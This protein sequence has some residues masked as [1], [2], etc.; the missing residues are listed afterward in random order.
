[1]LV[2]VK[3]MGWSM[4]NGMV[5]RGSSMMMWGI[6]RLWGERELILVVLYQSLKPFTLTLMYVLK[7][8]P[9]IMLFFVAL[10]PDFE[11]EVSTEPLGIDKLL[12]GEFVFVI[13]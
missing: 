12:N 10:P 1:M 11:L 9:F 8:G 3:V 2:V 5:T 6:V 13:D 4:A 7:V